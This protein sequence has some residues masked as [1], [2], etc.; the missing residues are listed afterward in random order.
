[1]TN[2]IDRKFLG[3]AI[4]YQKARPDYPKQLFIFLLDFWKQT[5]HH[6][7]KPTILDCGCGTGIATRGIYNAFHQKC[8]VIGIE[9]DLN[10]LEQAKKTTHD[11]NILYIEG[12]AE[13]LPFENKT[14][15]IVIA[16]QAI[17][18]FDRPLFYQE[19][20]RILKDNGVI[21][22]IENNRDW[23]NSQFLGEY[24]EFLEKN[25]YDEHLGYYSRDYRV[26]PFVEELSVYFHDEIGQS[27]SW[28]KK[29][30]PQDFW[31]IVKSS[32]S[33]KRVIA[34]L[35]Q[36][37]TELQLLELISTYLDVD[38][39]LNIPYISKAYLAKN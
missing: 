34:N 16:A 14:V 37:K 30:F 11:K 26:Y 8:K 18:Y 6:T 3:D 22:I 17:Q 19:A 12:N 36:E 25:S 4:S 20:K 2:K 1:M 35:G 13:K 29:M 15:D 23:R 7:D 27:F 38:G 31:E 28:S 5:S 32:T 10:M 9:P 21:G 24:E 39:F 33:G